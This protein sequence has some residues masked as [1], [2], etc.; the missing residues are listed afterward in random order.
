MV[1]S[2]LPP[3]RN[4]PRG[5]TLVAFL[6]AFAE[7]TRGIFRRPWQSLAVVATIALGVGLALA[8]SAVGRAVEANV[9]EMLAAG[10]LPPVFKVDSVTRTLDEARWIFTLLAYSYT[11]LLVLAVTGLSLRSLRR[12]VGVKRQA[13]VHIWE[14]VTEVL[15]QAVLLCLTGGA[16]G[17]LAGRGVCQLLTGYF[18][19][20]V[21]RPTAHDAAIVFLIGVLL[22]IGASAALAL[23][24]AFRPSSDQGL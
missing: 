2:P 7:G 21:V 11:A 4:P 19:A 17:I 5:E 24:L 23:P 1:T 10:P 14:V 18:S 8:L 20:L 22:G 6:I 3:E 12:E 16:V 13:G 9:S 15:V